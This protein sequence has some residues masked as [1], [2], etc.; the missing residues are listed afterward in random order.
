M[1][2]Y[3]RYDTLPV[4]YVQLPLQLVCAHTHDQQGKKAVGSIY[5]HASL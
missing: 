3:G 1:L 5:S 4:Q 2:Y